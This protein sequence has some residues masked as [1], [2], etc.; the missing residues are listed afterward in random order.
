MAVAPS[1]S[2]ALAAVPDRST[3]THAL[4][5]ARIRRCRYRRLTALETRSGRV[6]DVECCRT[7]SSPLPLGD[8]SI[9]RDIC[10]ACTAPG[11]FRDDED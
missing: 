5:A 3:G 4:S 6:Y 7:D 9:A 2:A 8:L 1:S 10:N 11:A